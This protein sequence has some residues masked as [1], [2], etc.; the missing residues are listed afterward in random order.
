MRKVFAP[1]V[2]YTY[3]DGSAVKSVTVVSARRHDAIQTKVCT[4]LVG[5]VH[6]RRI[7]TQYGYVDQNGVFLTDGQAWDVAE[8]AGQI[9]FHGEADHERQLT[10][11]NLYGPDLTTYEVKRNSEYQEA[12]KLALRHK[13]YHSPGEAGN[14]ADLLERLIDCASG[15]YII[16]TYVGKIDGVP[17]AVAMLTDDSRHLF[18]F[19]RS[20]ENNGLASKAILDTLSQALEQASKGRVT[21]DDCDQ[22]E[23]Q[24]LAL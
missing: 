7:S 20:K 16:P 1:A 15:Q 2:V 14:A 13:L 5:G 3:K 22:V 23:Q 9:R 12:A 4:A 21:S 24:A 11:Y 18:Y 6:S 19:D 17:A 10:C 8:Q